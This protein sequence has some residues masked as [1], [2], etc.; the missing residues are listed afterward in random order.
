MGEY[1]ALNLTYA[2][3]SEGVGDW[4]GQSVL[5]LQGVSYMSYL[6]KHIKGEKDLKKIVQRNNAS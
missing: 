6:K 5:D 2:A 3:L 1:E 4:M